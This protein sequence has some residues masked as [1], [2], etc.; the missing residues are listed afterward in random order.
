[1]SK[2]NPLTHWGHFLSVLFFTDILWPLEL[3]N[4]FISFNLLFFELGHCVLDVFDVFWN[5]RTVGKF[6]VGE[7]QN[8]DFFPQEDQDLKFY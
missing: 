2:A 1:M 8:A 5:K 3:G 7:R 6:M 4:I